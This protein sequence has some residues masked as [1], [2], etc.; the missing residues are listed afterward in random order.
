MRDN[1]G[2]LL[3]L[4]AAAVALLSAVVYFAA[5]GEDPEPSSAVRTRGGA[6]RE[7]TP[8]A[9][10]GERSPAV[11]GTQEGATGDPERPSE[12]P[13]E[14]TERDCGHPF[15]PS[16]VGEWR[17]YVWRQAGEERAAELRLEAT[18]TRELEDGQRE[19]SWRVSVTASDDASQLAQATMTTRCVPGQDAEEPWF[20]ILERSLDLT[21]TQDTPRWRWPAELVP[22]R[23]FEGTASFDPS[24]S[25]MRR[26]DDVVGP[27]LLRVTRGHVVGSEESVRVPAG[28]FRAQRVDYEERHAFGERGEDGTGT[29]WI[30]AD[31]GLVK[32]RAE[33]SQGVAQTIELVAFGRRGRAGSA[34]EP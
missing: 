29:L 18:G 7:N 14:G 31:V 20:G 4:G 2:R 22:G 30:A 11:S 23:R 16:R 8:E 27:Q 9:G 26:P 17:R 25:D 5:E 33:N 24:G 32:S 12:D 10:E 1:R 34:T 15:V 3:G 13:P 28:S 6:G 21:L 19:T